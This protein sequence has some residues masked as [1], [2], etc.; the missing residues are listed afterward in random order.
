MGTSRRQA[1]WIR[2]KGSL[3]LR[4]V[5]IPRVSAFALIPR[6]PIPI[7]LH[8]KKGTLHL[9]NPVRVPAHC[10]SLRYY[11]LVPRMKARYPFLWRKI[12]SLSSKHP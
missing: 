11:L 5:T 4:T 8:E 1:S 6:A 3:L 2:D 10:S 7:R 9:E 12:I